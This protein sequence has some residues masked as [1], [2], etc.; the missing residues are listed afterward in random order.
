MNP[1]MTP[2]KAERTRCEIIDLLSKGPALTA[3]ALADRLDLSIL[4]VRPR[5]SELVKQARIVASGDRGLN[6][7]GKSA[8]KWMVA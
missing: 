6:A 2:T 3:D 4:Y 8:Q 5:V 1:G 7:S